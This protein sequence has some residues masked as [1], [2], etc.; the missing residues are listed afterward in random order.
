[1]LFTPDFP[2]T[3]YPHSFRSLSYDPLRDLVAVAPAARSMLTYNVGPAVPA[4]VK[5]L[6]DFVQWCKAHPE[7]AAYATTAAGGTPHFV[8][9]MLASAAGIA[10]TPV[11]YRGG[12]PALQDLLGGH[13]PAGVNPISETLSQAKSGTL[14][15]LAVTGARRSPFLPD[16]PT[17]REQGYDVVAEAWLGAFVPAATP[18]ATV[19]TLGAAIND[20]V[21]SP[22]MAESLAR[23]GN[24]PAFQTP[25]EFAATVRA[26]IARW[27]PVV[28]ASG[29]VAED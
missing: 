3:L 19:R 16:V 8:G 13:V 2:I 10:M 21:R 12:A 23:F 26:D 28:K 27:G 7:S 6:A 5:S 11:H 17:M 15:I 25:D 24:E 4:S 18:A 1:M 9:V 20:A 14:R 22:D 29:F